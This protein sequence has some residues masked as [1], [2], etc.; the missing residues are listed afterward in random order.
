MEDVRLSKERIKKNK[1]LMIELYATNY[2][3]NNIVLRFNKLY[4]NNGVVS[5][6][7]VTP[8]VD[9]HRKF[10]LTV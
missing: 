8:V 7:I 3:C 6:Q 10:I 1:H 4:K 2:S 9:G 5:P